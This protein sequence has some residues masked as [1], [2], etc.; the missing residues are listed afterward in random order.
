M[1]RSV[2][3]IRDEWPPGPGDDVGGP[4]PANTAHSHRANETG[5]PTKSGGVRGPE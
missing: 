2:R 4:E 3:M 5:K 1:S